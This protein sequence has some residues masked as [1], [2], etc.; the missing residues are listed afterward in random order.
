MTRIVVLTLIVL[1]AAS[2]IALA[3]DPP[4][5]AKLKTVE[6]LE[7]AWPDHTEWVA[8]LVDI[9][10]GSQLG[11]GDGWFKKAVAQTR[12]NW[13]SV[14][15]KFDKDGDGSISRSEFA[16]KDG[17]FARLDRDR[18]GAL[19]SADFD[20]SPHALTPSPGMSLFSM[21]DADGKCGRSLARNSLASSTASTATIS[22][23]SRRKS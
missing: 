6:I 9:L 21:A 17:D 15:V 7:K 19:T 3:D 1:L 10:Q 23:S 22:S 2:P 4:N 18:D 13:D 16:G 14:K 20:F 12:F 8:M 11:P 5:T